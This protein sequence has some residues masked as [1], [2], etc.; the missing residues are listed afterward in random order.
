LN[1]REDWWEYT[2]RIIRS[3]P[4]LARKAE[5]VG[6]MPCTPAYGT[7]GGHGGTNSNPVERAVV[8]RLTD[9]EQRRYDAVR[10]AISG[11]ERMKHGHQRMELIDRVYWKRSH[12]LYGAAMCVGVSDRTGQ[13]WNA[14]FIRRVGKNLDLP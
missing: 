12:T 5:S 2:K 9:K 11:T 13:R 6:D 14:E 3:Y 7:G 4:A 8:D 10:A 1:N